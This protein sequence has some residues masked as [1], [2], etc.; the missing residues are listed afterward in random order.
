MAHASW[1]CESW[2]LLDRILSSVPYE[3][4][5]TE[6]AFQYFPNTSQ[7][8]AASG[9]PVKLA[10]SRTTKCMRVR[11]TAYAIVNLEMSL[12]AVESHSK[13]SQTRNC[14]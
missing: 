5:D 1:S 14:A 7:V 10:G 9:Q 4:T 3:P 8:V 13:C 12:S 11:L 6:Y 2:G